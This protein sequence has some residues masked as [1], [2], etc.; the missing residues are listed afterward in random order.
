[1]GCPCELIDDDEILICLTPRNNSPLHIVRIICI[2]VIVHN[3][4]LFDH[5]E[6]KQKEDHDS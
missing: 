5:G 4:D 6:G 1:M 3:N 2:Y